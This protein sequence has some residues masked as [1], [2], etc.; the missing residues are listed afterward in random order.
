MNEPIA[1][2]LFSDGTGARYAVPLHALEPYR[3][4]GS[5]DDEVAALF[6][7]QS[8]QDVGG[9][10]GVRSPHAA[11]LYRSHGESAELNMIQLDSLVAQR[12]VALQLTAGFMQAFNEGSK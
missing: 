12:G 5:L 7:D 4:T 8:N 9:Y 3:L 10:G 2:L 6:N 1:M 11:L